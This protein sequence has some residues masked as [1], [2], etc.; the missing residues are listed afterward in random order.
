MHIIQKVFYPDLIPVSYTHLDV[1]KRQYLTSPYLIP[2]DE[3]LSALRTAAQAGVDVRIIT[4]KIG[5]HAFVHLTTRSFYGDLLEAGVKIYE[6]TPGFIHSKTMAVDGYAAA[7]GSVNIDYRSFF[8]HFECGAWM[9][10]CDAVR[11]VHA[12]FLD[13]LTVSEEISL[14]EWK[15][16]PWFV[17][18]GQALLLS[19]I[20]ICCCTAASS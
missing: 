3:T 1:Y 20:H 5:D 9:C 16:R 14:D 13:T 12:D 4:P 18:A 7:V 8:L 6:Y 11:A 2:D 15:R 19:L 17:K 10:G